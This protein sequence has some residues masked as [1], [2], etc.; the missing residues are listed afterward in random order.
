[1]VQSSARKSRKSTI[2]DDIPSNELTPLQEF[3]KLHYQEHYDDHHPGLLQ[4]GESDVINS[5]KPVSCPV[6]GSVHIYKHGFTQ[7][8]VHARIK[9]SLYA[10]SSFD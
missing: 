4:T 1:M 2:W 6:C 7:N 5:F 8:H 3:I 9:N 10:H